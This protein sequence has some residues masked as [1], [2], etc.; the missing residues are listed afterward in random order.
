MRKRADSLLS[1]SVK[2]PSLPH[3]S[4]STATLVAS[5][6][7]DIGQ[8][9]KPEIQAETHAAA[10]FQSKGTNGQVNKCYARNILRREQWSFGFPR[11]LCRF[12]GLSRIKAHYQ[13]DQRG[14]EL[15]VLA[16]GQRTN[17]HFPKGAADERST[18]LQQTSDDPPSTWP[19]PRSLLPKAGAP[20]RSTRPRRSEPVDFPNERV[21]RPNRYVLREPD[22]SNF[23]RCRRHNP[24]PGFGHTISQ[25]TLDSFGSSYSLMT[26]QIPV[27]S[28]SISA[29][30]A[31]NTSVV[32][33]VAETL[34]VA[35]APTTT[36]VEA[37]DALSNMP[38]SSGRQRG[39]AVS[40]CVCRELHF[41]GR[42]ANGDN[43]AHD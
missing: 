31:T 24:V 17:D 41:N 4:R 30:D 5:S 28:H 37:F 23:R 9:P 27:G 14:S 16:V 8:P 22:A 34:N 38:V 29:H 7:G 21:L 43:A 25:T 18:I 36:A 26:N 1:V 12:S 3:G 10:G 32:D 40:C 11:T 35:P 39:G 15:V 42:D 20:G 13:F 19:G 33:S 2:C 6:S